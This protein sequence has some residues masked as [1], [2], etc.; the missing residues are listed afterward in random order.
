MEQFKQVKRTKGLKLRDHLNPQFGLQF[1]DFSSSSLNQFLCQFEILSLELQARDTLQN[2]CTCP[3]SNASFVRV[4]ISVK[5]ETVKAGYI[6]Y[7]AEIAVVTYCKGKKDSA[8]KPKLRTLRNN[9]MANH[10][11]IS[12]SWNNCTERK[13]SHYCQ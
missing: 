11:I 8:E 13:I 10:Q 3:I 9:R 7:S 6:G 5:M 4:T 12:N 2:I 1:T